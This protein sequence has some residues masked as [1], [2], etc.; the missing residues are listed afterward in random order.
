MDIKAL[1]APDKITHF[2]YGIIA[3]V[4]CVIASFLG[5]ALGLMPITVILLIGGWGSGLAVEATQYQD[6][7]KAEA[8]GLPPPHGVEFLDAFASA[9]ACTI[10][11]VGLEVVRYFGTLPDH[12]VFTYGKQAIWGVLG[13]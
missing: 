13:T 11:A 1:F 9:L 7:K 8:E 12:P 6:N 4:V 10:L 5:S 2:K 3:A